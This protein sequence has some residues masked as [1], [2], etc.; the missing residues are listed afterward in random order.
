M[1]LCAALELID[2][3][4]FGESLVRDEGSIIVTRVSYK[5][6]FYFYGRQEAL[7]YFLY[8][9]QRLLAKDRTVLQQSV[10]VGPADTQELR[11]KLEDSSHWV[12]FRMLSMQGPAGRMRHG[13]GDLG[14][15]ICYSAERRTLEYS[16]VE[17]VL[18]IF[19]DQQ[20]VNRVPSGGLA[21]Q[22]QVGGISTKPGNVLSNPPQSFDLIQ[23]AEIRGTTPAIW[24]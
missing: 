21:K 6:W 1:N 22:C 12:R 10:A 11:I 7:M 4:R 3:V 19:Y 24:R 2:K 9:R 8:G 18:S 17:Q 5:D 16:A 14:E 23:K 15:I 13:C 20:A